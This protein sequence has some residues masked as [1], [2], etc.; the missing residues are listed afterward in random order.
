MLPV[1]QEIK[2]TASQRHQL[3]AIKMIADTAIVLAQKTP[4]SM[5]Q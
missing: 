4:W 5:P 3:L 2:K 1:P